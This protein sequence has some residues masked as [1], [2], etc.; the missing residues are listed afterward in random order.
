ME[1]EI[2]WFEVRIS[3]PWL[4]FEV[5]VLS[6]NFGGFGSGLRSVKLVGFFCSLSSV[7]DDYILI[8]RFELGFLVTV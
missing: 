3:L 1:R 6:L 5:R 4:K 7:I 8:L 2:P